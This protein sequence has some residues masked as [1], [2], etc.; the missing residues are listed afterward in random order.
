[1]VDGEHVLGVTAAGTLMSQPSKFVVTANDVKLVAFVAAVVA[2]VL[3][4]YA[5]M[6]A[7]LP[8]SSKRQPQ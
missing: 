7:P 5:L 8:R 6:T 4:Q 2:F 3:V 1:M